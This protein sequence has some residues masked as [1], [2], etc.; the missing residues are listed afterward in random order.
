VG[1]AVANAVYILTGQRVR[2]LPLKNY[3]FTAAPAERVA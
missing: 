3:R 2:E 1:A